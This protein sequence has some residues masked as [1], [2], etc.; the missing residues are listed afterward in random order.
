MNIL[1]N[2]AVTL[3]AD[4]NGGNF[5]IKK[6]TGLGPADIRTS[7]FLYSGRPGG[8]V[9]DQQSGF[10][11]VSIEGKI[12][13]IGGNR[14]DHAAD[15]QALLAALP[16]G[17]KIPVY[18]TNF[19]GEQFR[20]DANVTDAKVEYAQGGYTS[21]YMIQLTA[22]DPLFYNV[23]GGDEQ[24]AI[25]NRTIDNGGYVTP[26]IL[27]VEWDSGGQPTI[28]LNSGNAV[29]Y[30][31]ITIYDET[32]DPILTN[33]ATGE[34]FA[35]SINTNDGDE[36]VIDMLNRTVKLNGSD[37]IGNKVDGSVWFGLL[38]GNNPIRFDTDTVDDTGYADIV[39]RNGVTGI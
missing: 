10:R 31:T 20:I 13:E 39:W 34:Q 6:V 33:Q 36:L 5:I 15:R 4:P 38:V 14:V 17:T 23:S 19:A 30:P 1:L 29:V 18:I 16:I 27:P 2:E 26:Y 9:T 8:L 32:H 28:V 37:V 24:S 3:S 22:G 35:M 25:V 7:S 21:D 12:G 11:M